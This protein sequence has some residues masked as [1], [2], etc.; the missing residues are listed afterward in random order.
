MTCDL[1]PPPP[2]TRHL[3]SASTPPTPPAAS[4]ISIMATATSN[5][6]DA[7]VGDGELGVKPPSDVVIPPKGVRESI[8]KT[9]EFVFRR[10][11]HFEEIMRK[12]AR[13]DP[14]TK[15]S[16]LFQEDEYY[17][18]FTWYLQQLRDG[19]GPSVAGSQAVVQDNKPKGP[20]EP[21]KFLFSARMP[22]ISAQD[23]DILKATALWTASN[24][25][26]WLKELRTRESGN[27]QFDFLRANHSFFQFFRALVDQYKSLLLGEDTEARIEELQQNIKNRFHILER[28]RERAEYIKFVSQQ[29]EKE[30]K[31][32]EDE[33]KEY[34]SI[35]WHEFAVIATVTFDEADD[36]ADLPPPMTLHDLQSASLEQKA[37]V[38]LSS[39]RLE[40]AMPDQE[41]YYNAS[42]AQSH[43]QNNMYP[44][45]APAFAPAV[46]PVWPPT[47]TDYRSPAQT[48]REEEEARFTQERQAEHERAAQAQ[49]AAR[50]APGSMRIR[51]DYVPRAAA[52]KANVAMV[53]CPNCKQ[54]FRADEIDEHI[55]SMFSFINYNPSDQTLTCV[56]SRASRSTLE[57]DARQ[58]RLTV[59][60]YHQH[61][62]RGRQPQ[63]LCQPAR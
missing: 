21:P 11:E 25:E 28:A 19:Q 38:S 2:P 43:M 53:G 52:K 32:V 50:G 7:S 55:R 56:S 62:R 46:Q 39:R 49:A 44:P 16:F 18:Y 57:G 8:A 34:A 37:A 40:E 41:T 60:Y 54:Q 31:Q 58:V 15:F 9:A 48:F 61:G 33:K 10:G 27:F 35:D 51:N 59:L 42:R 17:K 14:R 13:A 36:L 47:S 5:G 4:T 26:N 20:P 29:K 24:G 30:E 12:R 3:H 22:N 23:L 63:A 1:E 45:M 6:A